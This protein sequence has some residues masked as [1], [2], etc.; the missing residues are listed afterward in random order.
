MSSNN[1]DKSVNNVQ[2]TTPDLQCSICLGD[3]INRCHS[4]TCSH[5]FCFECLRLWSTVSYL[6]N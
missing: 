1:G 5:M 2:P 4:D 6:N 3:L